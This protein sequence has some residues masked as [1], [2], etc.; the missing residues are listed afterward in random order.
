[1]LRSETGP[2]RYLMGSSFIFTG[3]VKG[4]SWKEMLHHVTFFSNFLVAVHYGSPSG[5]GGWH[6]LYNLV[7]NAETDRARWW[8]QHHFQKPDV[9]SLHQIHMSSSLKGSRA[10]PVRPKPR[11]QPRENTPVRTHVHLRPLIPMPRWKPMETQ[12]LGNQ[13]QKPAGA[14]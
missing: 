4:D 14:F 6:N 9:I 2:S 10:P 5:G 8:F 12:M 13:P 7:R 3:G 11:C 1:M